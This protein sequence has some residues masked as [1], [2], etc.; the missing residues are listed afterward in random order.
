M[1]LD[2]SRGRDVSL[3]SE[4]VGNGGDLLRCRRVFSIVFL[5][6]RGHRLLAA[7]FAVVVH[8]VHKARR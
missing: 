8:A 5:P 3:D 1:I 6:G 2:D 4:R 7:T